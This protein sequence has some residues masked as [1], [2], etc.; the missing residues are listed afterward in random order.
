MVYWKHVVYWSQ[1]NHACGPT[2]KQHGC[3]L[4]RPL[5]VSSSLL[6]TNVFFKDFCRQFRCKVAV[7][8]W[9]KADIILV[10]VMGWVDLRSN[11]EVVGRP[12]T[13]E[14]I[15]KRI[16]VFPKIGVSQNGWFTMEHPIKVN[17]LGVPLC[18]VQHPFGKRM[19]GTFQEKD[20]FL[21][22][23]CG[24][25]QASIFTDSILFPIHEAPLDVA[26]VES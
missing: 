9:H 25:Y 2:P 12:K 20:S 7:Q 6:R 21:Q 4:E 14:R 16:W 13:N 17:D 22:I 18:L 26:K 5:L 10:G 11:Q 24:L 8:D 15:V 1:S 23:G 19:A 3:L